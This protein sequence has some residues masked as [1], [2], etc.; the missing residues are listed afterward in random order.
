[1]GLD[2]ASRK[3]EWEHLLAVNERSDAPCF[4]SAANESQAGARSI[5]SREQR[6]KLEDYIDP[7]TRRNASSADPRIATLMEKNQALPSRLAV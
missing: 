6:L 4:G 3:G 2:A 7:R 5:A 1:M